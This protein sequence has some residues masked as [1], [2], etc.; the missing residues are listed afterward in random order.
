MHYVEDIFQTD[1]ISSLGLEKPVTVGRSASVG[2]ALSAVQSRG[3]G[4]VLVVDAGSPL[5]IM[6]EREVLMR[7]V[8]RDV[9]YRDNV[10]QY[11]DMSVPTLTERDRIAEAIRIMLETGAQNIPI[12]DGA[13]YAAAVLRAVDIMQFLAEAFPAQVLNLPPRPDQQM[14]KP[15]GA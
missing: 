5:G 4:Y 11:S 3:K 10:E 14:V 9:S 12:V 7:I 15:E 1:P 13:G 6:S 8:A 2:T